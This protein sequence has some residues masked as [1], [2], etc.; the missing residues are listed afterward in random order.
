MNLCTNAADAMEGTWVLNIS[1]K[2]AWL[3]AGV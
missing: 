2:S 1:T 3:W